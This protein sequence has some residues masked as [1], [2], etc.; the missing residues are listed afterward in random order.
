MPSISASRSTSFSCETGLRRSYQIS[1]HSS[2]RSTPPLRSSPTI[3]YRIQNT[4]LS[5]TTF[6]EGNNVVSRGHDISR[7]RWITC[8]AIGKRVFR[9]HN[10][11][12]RQLTVSSS[13]FLFVLIKLCARAT[14]NQ[15]RHL[16][17][18]VC[19]F[20]YRRPI[21]PVTNIIVTHSQD[22]LRSQQT[23]SLLNE[24]NRYRDVCA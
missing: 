7:P 24:D 20:I 1:V 3:F 19:C 12:R 22:L 23:H 2:R 8:K 11:S 4:S 15:H 10:R 14:L 18:T 21:K 17:F 16:Y 13:F 5:P 6:T 9:R